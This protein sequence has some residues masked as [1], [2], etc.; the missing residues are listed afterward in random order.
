MFKLIVSIDKFNNQFWKEICLNPF[1]YKFIGSLFY[2]ANRR[3]VKIL[4]GIDP[5]LKDGFNH[6]FKYREEN[7]Q[8]R[9][10]K[11]FRIIRSHNLNLSKSKLLIIGPRN[12]SELLLAFFHGFR[13][14]NIFGLDLYSEHP[15]VKLANIEN[16]QNNNSEYDVIVCSGVLNYVNKLSLSMNNLIKLTKNGGLIVIQTDLNEK[17]DKDVSYNLSGDLNIDEKIKLVEKN[18]EMVTFR[19]DIKSIYKGNLHQY[20]A[21]KVK[22]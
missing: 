20:L 16:I 14:K 18:I 3:K 11:C 5:I 15:K 4:K 9:P 13:W 10:N 21:F 8:D 6:N 7:L 17:L 12:F 1:I 2:F 22:K 19:E